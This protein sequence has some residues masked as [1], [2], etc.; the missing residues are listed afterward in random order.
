MP[1][2]ASYEAKTHAA[3]GGA[4]IDTSDPKTL[5]WLIRHGYA[6]Y[7]AGLEILC[8]LMMKLLC[9]LYLRKVE[10]I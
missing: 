7:I 1:E 10:S 6:V 4:P 3:F 9:A 2:F 8:M 5:A